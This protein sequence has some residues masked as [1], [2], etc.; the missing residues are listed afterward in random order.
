[1]NKLS[2]LKE[3]DRLYAYF[4]INYQ[5]VRTQLIVSDE[6][7]RTREAMNDSYLDEDYIIAVA[8]DGRENWVGYHNNQLYLVSKDGFVFYDSAILKLEKLEKLEI[9]YEE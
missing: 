5:L 1:M 4:V 9:N 2:D 3:G 8:A 6:T 7:I